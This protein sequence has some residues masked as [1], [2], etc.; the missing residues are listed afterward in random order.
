MKLVSGHNALNRDREH[1]KKFLLTYQ[2]KICFG[3]DYYDSVHKDLLES[4]GLPETV[5]TKI[6]EGNARKI[7]RNGDKTK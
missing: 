7:L 4:L 3:R 6:F 2:D 5:L 1:A